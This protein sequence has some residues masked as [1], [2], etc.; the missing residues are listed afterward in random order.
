MIAGICL[1]W[2]WVLAALALTY[3]IL[4]C[5]YYYDDNG[6]KSDLQAEYP[7]WA[8]LAFC[9]YPFIPVVNVVGFVF[10]CFMLT[11]A[12]QRKDAYLRGRFFDDVKRNQPQKESEE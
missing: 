8:W 4:N 6:Q 7:V 12:E 3:V 10:L 2:V 1:Y 5:V 11:M 9:L